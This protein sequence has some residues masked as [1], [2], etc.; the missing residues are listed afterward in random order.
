MPIKKPHNN[1]RDNSRRRD[2]NDQPRVN[3]RIRAPRVRVVRA[4]GEQVGIMSTR[5]ALDLAKQEGLDLVEIAA[6]TDPP[7]CRIV[8][9]GKFKYQQAKQQKNNNSKTARQKE[10]KLGVAIDV[11]DYN[12]KMA[13]AE[14]F[15]DA[16]H[17]VRF[18]IRLKG[19]QNA[20]PELA[21][22]KLNQVIADMKSM[23]A[24]D[25]APRQAG[26]TSSMLLTP[27]PKQQRVLKFGNIEVTEEDDDADDD[28]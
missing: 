25:Q 4:T 23:A 28:E 10:I 5:E 6:T 1:D 22:E 18:V 3:E 8:D 15:L 7:V 19:R 27:L 24:V 21:L 11:N 20:H 13:R 16:G 17:K 14:R 9:Y 26:A 2:R 12:V